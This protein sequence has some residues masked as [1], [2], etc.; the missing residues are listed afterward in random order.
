MVINFFPTSIAYEIST[1][2]STYIAFEKLRRTSE[3][4]VLA[5]SLWF[6]FAF[7]AIFISIAIPCVR[8]TTVIFASEL[9]RCARN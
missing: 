2:T 9:I 1:N 7:R 4:A 3:I 8:Y 5:L 6:V